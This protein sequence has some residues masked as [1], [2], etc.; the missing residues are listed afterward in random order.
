MNAEVMEFIR[1][2]M[3]NQYKKLHEA[4]KL[5][6]EKHGLL[7]KKIYDEYR[8]RLIAQLEKKD[9]TSI[10]QVQATLERFID[11]LSNLSHKEAVLAKEVKLKQSARK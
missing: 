4:L 11:S 3:K 1:I 8:A 2:E 10:H 7:K 6:E 5:S 9:K